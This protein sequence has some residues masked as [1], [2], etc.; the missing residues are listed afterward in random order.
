MAEQ[1]KEIP[2]LT[3]IENSYKSGQP[4]LQIVVDR[5]RAADFGLSAAQVG[6]TVRTLLARRDGQHLPR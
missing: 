2:G 1:L 3:D 6:S 4:E 5:Q